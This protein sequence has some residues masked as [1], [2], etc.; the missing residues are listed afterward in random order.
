MHSDSTP[1]RAGQYATAG[2]F[3]LIAL[4]VIVSDII[5]PDMLAHWRLEHSI[6][7]MI[8]V[9]ATLAVEAAVSSWCDHRRALAVGFGIVATACICLVA[10][11]SAGRQAATQSERDRVALAHNARIDAARTRLDD[12]VAAKAKIDADAVVAVKERY[13]AKEC[14]GHLND[15]KEAAAKEVAA[16]RA[17]LAAMPPPLAVGSPKAT[18]WADTLSGVLPPAVTERLAPRVEY[19]SLALLAE[20]GAMFG[21]L[22]L[23]RRPKQA[24]TPVN[25]GSAAAQ[26]TPEPNTVAEQIEHAAEQLAIAPETPPAAIKTT[27][28][29][30]KP[31]AVKTRRKTPSEI[32]SD[33]MLRQATGRGFKSDTEAARHYGYSRSRFSELQKQWKKDGALV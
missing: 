21:W 28:R 22:A 2:I 19:L 14:V 25:T 7:V 30:S 18:W 32:R 8:V 31:K 33:L 5:G 1:A 9:A 11:N 23:R 24:E 26:P 10:Y 27:V 6:A 3:T 17:A 13:C 15:S 29:K 12:A 16:A 20:F 4:T